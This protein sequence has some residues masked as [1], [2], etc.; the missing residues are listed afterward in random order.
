MII[1]GFGLWDLEFG[2][3]IKNADGESAGNCIEMKL[4]AGAVQG[5][6]GC[7]M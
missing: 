1:R 4:E 3:N 5:L 2:H 6:A 7:V